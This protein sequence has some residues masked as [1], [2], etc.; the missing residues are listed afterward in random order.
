MKIARMSG[1][2]IDPCGTPAESLTVDNR[3]PSTA[4]K[5]SRSA[6]YGS[7]QE[8]NS[9]LTHAEGDDGGRECRKLSWYLVTAARMKIDCQQQSKGR[10]PP[11]SLQFQWSGGYGRI[12][13]VK[14]KILLTSIQIFYIVKLADP[15][16]HGRL[17]AQ[18]YNW[19]TYLYTGHLGRSCYSALK[20]L[21]IVNWYE[22]KINAQ[23]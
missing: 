22:D 11:C 19:I 8:S 20:T 5:C 18:M 12:D 6:R 14:I 2:R 17:N 10:S 23:E 1:S 3:W 16:S 9:S 21:T 15:R 7:C 13:F 4:T